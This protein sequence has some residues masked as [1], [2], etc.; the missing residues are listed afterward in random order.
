VSRIA[1]VIG[2]ALAL[3]VAASSLAIDESLAQT[4]ASAPKPGPTVSPLL[5]DAAAEVWGIV[6]APENPVWPGWNASDTPLLLYLPGKQDLLINHPHPP[7]GFRPYSGPL[8]FPRGKMM[9]KD[10]PTIISFDGQNTAM[11]VAGV[12]TLVVADPLSNL[13]QRVTG[14]I[15]DPRPAA[16]KTRALE[17]ADLMANPYDQLALIVHEAFHVHQQR[18]A[19]HRDTN[20]MLLLYYPVLSVEN[21]VG[22]ALEGDALVTAARAKDAATLRAAALRWLALR[23]D[24]R[25]ALPVRAVQYEDGIEFAEG[26]AKYT[27]YRLFQVLEG[28][29]PA[30]GL[31]RA[32][33]FHGYADLSA[34]REELLRQTLANMRG[35]VNV[36]NDPY[37]TAPLRM[38]LYYSGMSIA[39]LLDRLSPGWKREAFAS[40]SSLTAI[41]RDAL[42]ATPTELEAAL[43]AARS[44]AEYDTLVAAKQRLAEEGKKRIDAR[45]AA[46]EQGSGTSLIVDYSALASKN[47]GLSFSPFGITVVDPDRVIFEQVPIQAGFSDGSELKQSVALPLLRDTKQRRVRCPLDRRVSREEFV[48]LLG[49]GKSENAALGPADLDLPGVKLH[50]THGAARWTDGAIV[51]TLTPAPDGGAA[52]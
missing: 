33:G 14:W 49:P 26:L 22:M 4:A 19:P 11:D 1:R 36:N 35:E 6:A 52:K 21:N 31:A 12:R 30:P 13:R 45:L 5:V 7:E 24:R 15:E 46:I 27:E 37:G 2:V 40:D 43:A 18:S 29:R 47:L 42:K 8:T 44:G 51:V 32:Q 28:R 23:G 41:A 9:V 25:R 10:G 48:R 34:E 16:E 50:V 3:T 20:E 38:R 39:L 17:L